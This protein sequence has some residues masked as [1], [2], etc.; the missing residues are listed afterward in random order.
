MSQRWSNLLVWAGTIAFIVLVSK[1]AW[2]GNPVNGTSLTN[3][4]VLALPVAGIIAM[5]AT[6]LVV[7]YTTTGVFNF[8]QG[9][10]GMFLAYVDWELTVAHGV[11]QAVALPLVVL[12]IAPLL[13]IGLDRAIMR[14]LQGKQLVVQLMV[15]V[16]LLF[17]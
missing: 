3:L 12:V 15:T 8:A 9:A 13:G 16:G 7:V 17:A 6:G 4:V 14:H 5:S 10:I 2:A 1:A 11:P